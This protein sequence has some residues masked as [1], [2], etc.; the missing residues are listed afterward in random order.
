MPIGIVVCVFMQSAL[1]GTSI[2]VDAMPDIGATAHQT[3]TTSPTPP[4][5]SEGLVRNGPQFPISQSVGTFNVEGFVRGGWPFVIDFMSQRDSCTW[6][7]ITT[8]E[9]KSW[10]RILD[11]D[12]SAG[13]HILKIDLPENLASEPRPAQYAIYSIQQTCTTGTEAVPEKVRQYSPIVVYGIGGGPRAVGS[14]AVNKL[15]FGPPT[16]QFPQEVAT[17]DYLT[18]SDFGRVSQEILS[19]QQTGP[20]QWIVV[21]IRASQLYATIHGSHHGNWDGTGQAG[22]RMPGIYRLQVRAW[23]TVNDEKSWVGAISQDSVHISQP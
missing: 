20:G 16:P 19:Y 4:V 15:Q 13:R 6:L 8:D 3:A 17:F 2:D 12:G 14:V 23:N 9:K 1:G 10:R 22:N 5:D 11:M 7:E 21:L 18:E